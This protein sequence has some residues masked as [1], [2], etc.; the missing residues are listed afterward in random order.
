MRIG[1]FSDTHTQHKWVELLKPVDYLIFAGDGEF[2]NPGDIIS[3]NEWLGK[4]KKHGDIKE[5]L[6]TSGNHDFYPQKHLKETKELF[7]NGVYLQHE[8]YTL[9]NG[10]NV[11]M[12]PMSVT[13][14]DWAF[15]QSEAKLEK[16]YWSKIPSNTNILVTHS[17]PY[18]YLDYDLKHGYL[19]SK[20][21]AKRVEE[22]KPKYHVFGHIHRD[23]G[24]RRIQETE[25]TT[26]VNAS[27]LD[28]RYNMI[29]DPI[30]VDV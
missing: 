14:M 29:H 21:L 15:M 2:R 4:L 26:F 13:F 11:Y 27:V 16:D 6:I 20:T 18:N 10:M 5:A 23:E 8:T 1:F 19:G 30:I 3:F 12:S 7:T 17:P 9:S 25:H 28:N 22:L 24:Q